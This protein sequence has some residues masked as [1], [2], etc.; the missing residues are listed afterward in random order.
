M[1]CG[2]RNFICYSSAESDEVL[3]YQKVQSQNSARS[4]FYSAL[5]TI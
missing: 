5:D 4:S 2:V 1:H 3:V